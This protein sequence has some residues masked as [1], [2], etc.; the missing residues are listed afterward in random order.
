[1][2][3]LEWDEYETGEDNLHSPSAAL[4]GWQLSREEKQQVLHLLQNLS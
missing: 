3:E 1:M 4:N 2:D